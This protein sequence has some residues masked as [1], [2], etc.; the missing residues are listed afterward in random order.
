MAPGVWRVS[1]ITHLTCL[2]H[3]EAHSTCSINLTLIIITGTSPVLLASPPQPEFTL[4]LQAWLLL[5]F[6]PYL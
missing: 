5:A 4:A 2:A 3:S 1:E 6:V